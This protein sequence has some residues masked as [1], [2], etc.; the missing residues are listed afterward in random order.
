MTVTRCICHS[1]TFAE[2]KAL[3]AANEWTTVGEI[4]L[5]TRCGLGCGSCRIYL[6][7]MLD[8]GATAFTIAEPGQKPKPAKPEPWE[9]AC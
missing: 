2:L 8:T 6:Q 7:A 4:S 9:V 1:K 5:E 3:C